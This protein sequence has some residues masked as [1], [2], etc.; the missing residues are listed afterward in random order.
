MIDSSLRVSGTNVFMTGS[1]A[2][3][4]LGP[5][6]G[7]L[8]GARMAARKICREIT[9]TDLAPDAAAIPTPGAVVSTAERST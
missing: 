9:G 3:I 1:L 8:W 4:E 6:A 2:T 5:A 7:N